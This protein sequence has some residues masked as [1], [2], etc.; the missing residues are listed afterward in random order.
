[1]KKFHIRPLPYTARDVQTPKRPG[2]GP[3][4]SGQGV[5][6]VYAYIT[7]LQPAHVLHP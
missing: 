2:T 7:W 3:K 1:M 5:A 6:Y 4:N